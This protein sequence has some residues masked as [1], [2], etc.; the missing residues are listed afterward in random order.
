MQSSY[1]VMLTKSTS[2]FTLHLNDLLV[3][4][5]SKGKSEELHEN[6]QKN[7]H[8]ASLMFAMNHQHIQ[9]TKNLHS[10]RLNKL[11]KET[12]KI[13]FWNFSCYFFL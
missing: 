5:F 4:E 13:S 3:S 12:E 7:S 9:H 2:K 10:N 6:V 11:K 8:H 1:A